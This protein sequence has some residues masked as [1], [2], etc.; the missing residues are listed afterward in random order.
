MAEVDVEAGKVYQLEVR[1][2]QLQAT[3]RHV[4]PTW[5]PSFATKATLISTTDR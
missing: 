4:L 2:S 1:F 3:Q 5:V